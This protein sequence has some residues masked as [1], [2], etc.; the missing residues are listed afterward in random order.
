MLCAGAAMDA[1]QGRP[2]SIGDLLGRRYRLGVQIGT[3]AAGRVFRARDTLLGRE[4]AVKVLHSVG[5]TPG[6]RHCSHVEEARG[7]ARLIHPNI[8]RTLDTGVHAG[9]GFIAMELVEGGTLADLLSRDGRL[10]PEQ[11]VKIAA[12][13]ADALNHAHA[14]G[15]V[16]CD[17]KPQNI[18]LTR[19]GVPKL[20]D[21]GVAR[22]AWDR[23]LDGSTSPRGTAA[24]VAPEQALGQLLDGRADLYA[25]GAVLYEMLAGRPPF[26]G[27]SFA[28]VV[29]QRLVADPI[30]LQSLRPG[31]RRELTEAVARALARE[32]D[33]R[34]RTGG[35]LR[36]ALVEAARPGAWHVQAASYSR[37]GAGDVVAALGCARR[38]ARQLLRRGW[39]AACTLTGRLWGP[40]QRG[41][42]AQCHDSR[43]LDKQPPRPSR[44]YSTVDTSCRTS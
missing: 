1:P 42:Q 41:G 19:D 23:P 30:P 37:E 36:R 6:V 3:G 9:F 32:P 15:I 16:H 28:A 43:R 35:E 14:R 11:A 38:H 4:V 21:F 26:I 44:G 22:T 31:L 17:V 27:E 2:P 5:D 20:V 33:D 39:H 7:P 25:L 18:L 8:A 10:T 29:S 12:D 24:Y 34:F 40:A 13:L